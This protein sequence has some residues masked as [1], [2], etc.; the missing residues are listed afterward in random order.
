MKILKL[1]TFISAGV[2]MFFS[3]TELPD[4]NND[5]GN[6]NGDDGNDPV[7]STE[8]VLL[9]SEMIIHAN[10]ED[11]VQFTVLSDGEPVTEGVR[12]Y[13]GSSKQIELPDMKF[14]T[15]EPGAYSFWAAYGTSHTDIVTIT[16]IG[17]PVPE[18]PEDPEPENTSFARRVLLTQFTGTGCGY[19]PGMIELLRSVMADEDYSSRTVLTACHS[20]NSNDPAFYSGG[21]DMALGVMGYPMVVADMSLSY[22]NYNNL[23]GLKNTIDAAYDSS[24]AKAGISARAELDGNTLVV[25]ASVKAAE[26]SEFRIGAWLLED[27]IEGQQANY[28]AASWTGDYNTHDNCIRVADS[29]LSNTNFTG[30]SLGT[31]EAGETA[32]YAFVINIEE[33]WVAENCHLALF[34]TAPEAESSDIFTVNN[35]VSCDINGEVTY[36]YS[37]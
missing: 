4:E 12:F 6:D 17:F 1:L 32:E 33:G 11:A 8:L 19:C 14:T 15:T 16:A 36:Q 23:A 26:T 37:E 13:D 22:N 20:Y 35:A 21:L 31:I 27:G 10:G 34:I 25:I 9:A 30:H 5:N 28:N 18:L 3:C 7:G 2:M 24:P 29:R